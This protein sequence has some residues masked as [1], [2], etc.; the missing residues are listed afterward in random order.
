MAGSLGSV[1][2]QIRL[3]ISQAI[4]AYAQV[5]AANSTT[6]YA[7]R[8]AGSTLT[9]MG[10]GFTAVGLGL[11]A[12]LGKGIEAAATFEKRLDYFGA[13]SATTAGQMELVRKKAIELGRDTIYSANDIA[14]AFVELGKAGV[15]SDLILSGVGKAVANIGAA[16]DIPL[17]TAANIM[18]AAVQSFNLS[19]NDA[20][21]VADLLAA[22]ANSSTVDVQ[23][24]GVSLKYVGGVA[25]AMGIGIDDSIDAL[26]LLGKYGIRGSTAGTSLRQIL[27]SLP[28]AT[29][30]ATAMLKQLG[31][32]TEDGSNKFFDAQ[33]HAK[34]LSDIFQTLQEATKGMTDEQRI[35]A[36]KTIFQNRALAA[37]IDLS[38]EG[39]KGFSAMD[40]QLQ[41]TTAADVAAKR[42]DNLSGD[43]EILRGNI[44]TLFIQAGTPFQNFLRGIVQGVTAVIGA[45]GSLSPGMQKI[46]II[47]MAVAA[48][49]ALIIGAALTVAGVILSMAANLVTAAPAFQLVRT[50]ILIV[51]NALRAL[52]VAALAN[53]F[54][55]IIVAIIALV[56]GFILLYKHSETFRNFINAIPGAIMAAWNGMIGWFQSL[57]GMFAGWWG[58]IQSV[59]SSVWGAIV[60]FVGTIPGLLMSFFLNWT[61]PGLLISH[62]ESIKSGVVTA[63]NAVVGFFAA[64]PG[65]IM[66][67]LMALPGQIGYLLGFIIGTIV[68][69]NIEAVTWM[70]NTAI[71]IYQGVTG[72]FAQ[73]PGRIAVFLVELYNNAV[74]WFTNLMVNAI[75][76]AGSLYNGVVNWFQQ[77]PGRVIA[78]VAEMYNGAVTWVRNM[79]VQAVALAGQVVSGMVG[80]FQALPGR[81]GAF[82]SSMYS[83]AV[84]FLRS[85]LSD[86]RSMAGQIASAIET[87]VQRIPGIISD[88]A[89]KAI[90][91]FKTMVKGAFGA[92][93]DF[94]GGLWNGFKDGLGI[95]SPSYIE[96]AMWAITGVLDDETHLMKKQVG[97][98]QGLG[99]G[100]DAPTITAGVGYDTSALLQQHAAAMAASVGISQ[101]AAAAGASR[102]AGGITQG[103]PGATP[104]AA[105]TS[106]RPLIGVQNVYN[107]VAEPASQT[108]QNETRKRAM[109]PGGA[110]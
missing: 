5:R 76:L 91:A 43:I 33:G 103:S 106:S 29:K 7:L 69:W 45:F 6:L 28:G 51:I 61:L 3:D 105:G 53:P 13:V 37:A 22:A 93:K 68:R 101:Q 50:G 44:E 25:S 62:W 99:N 30:P 64:L 18:T 16:A 24:L 79:E 41:K 109:L 97:I 9:S 31:I 95:H 1:S 107:P 10:A 58:S 72:W 15:S 73:L 14:D 8:Q 38:K 78:F 40:A 81:I 70:V 21:H 52:T 75:A 17:A 55:L 39:A 57:P 89:G 80:F 12:G 36:Y 66:N 98:I 59:T 47:T 94:A 87:G 110:Y 71:Q 35:G 67:A 86:A 23:D 85:M 83:N 82:F 96:H 26:A 56:A 4:G 102:V 49:L 100:I 84:G 74:T 42:M 11:A 63:F 48:A 108:V 46:I 92:A 19:G 34:S 60:A 2:G 104:D 88:I 54:T 32:I 90:S 65:Q 27:V 77:L 20:V